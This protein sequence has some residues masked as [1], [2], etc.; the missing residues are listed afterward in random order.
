MDSDKFRHIVNLGLGKHVTRSKRATD[1]F[2]LDG[3]KTKCRGLAPEVSFGY[4]L[5]RD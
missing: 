5:G 4:W 3:P 1:I 2:K